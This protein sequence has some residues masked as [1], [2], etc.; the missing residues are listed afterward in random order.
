MRMRV[1]L[2]IL[3]I[4]LLLVGAGRA[5]ETGVESA[6][7]SIAE[8]PRRHVPEPRTDSAIHRRHREHILYIVALS[9]G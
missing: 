7:K 1:L 6:D 2:I 3:G 4:I 9:D 8:L 5:V